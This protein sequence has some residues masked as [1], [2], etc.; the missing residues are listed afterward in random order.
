MTQFV[1]AVMV[2]RKTFSGV[3]AA[4]VPWGTSTAK[5]TEKDVKVAGAGAVQV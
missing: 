5:S 2:G 4:V 1:E 3:A